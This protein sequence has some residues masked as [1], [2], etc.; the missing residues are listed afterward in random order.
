MAAE[1]PDCAVPEKSAPRRR[2]FLKCDGHEERLLPLSDKPFY[3]VGAGEQDI[4]LLGQRA[5][6]EHAFIYHDAKGTTFIM[7]RGS[8]SGVYMQKR[9][10]PAHVGYR[11]ECNSTIY[12]GDPTDRSVDKAS[13]KDPN[14]QKAS[15]ESV[16]ATAEQPPSRESVGAKAEPTPLSTSSSRTQVTAVRAE[17][18]P[19][20]ERPAKFSAQDSKA[21]VAPAS[22]SKAPEPAAAVAPSKD[23]RHEERRKSD[24][25]EDRQAKYSRPS[26]DSGVALASSK[27]VEKEESRKPDVE[28]AEKRRTEVTNERQAKH[29]RRSPSPAASEPASPS[30][31][32]PVF[33]PE[34]P[35]R[36]MKAGTTSVAPKRPEVVSQQQSQDSHKLRPAYGPAAPAANGLPNTRAGSGGVEVRRQATVCAPAKVSSAKAKCDKCDGPHATEACPHFK[37]KREDHKDAW[38]NYGKEHPARLGGSGGNFVLPSRSA[39]IVKQPGDGSCLFHSLC[40]G[41]RK[42]GLGDQAYQL[43]RQIANWIE[44]NP[45]EEIAGDTIEEWVSWDANTSVSAYARR[46][47]TG[48]AWGGGIEIAACALLKCTNIHVYE[49]SAGQFKRI[50]CFDSPK[51]TSRLVHILYQGGL[52]YDALYVNSHHSRR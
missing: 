25:V 50:S 26:S 33:G 48:H 47:A 28:R 45:R 9:R 22:C 17:E 46:M 41:L 6:S 19:L 15:R 3:C 32:L 42:C 4:P 20:A 2:L 8:A 52:H 44:A 43:R 1:P 51:P 36:S 34:P 38:V 40:Y 21:N 35:P 49:R 10:I 30:K 11:L 5:S 13:L 23:T 37:K 18:P 39:Q 31:P 14:W 29:A 24:A 12:F 27:R 7:D 16:G